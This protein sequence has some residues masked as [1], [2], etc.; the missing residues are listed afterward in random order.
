MILVA[1]EEASL[2]K[3]SFLLI[4]LVVYFQLLLP[5]LAKFGSIV[6]FTLILSSL[7][8]LLYNCIRSNIIV[9]PIKPEN[10]SSLDFAIE[11]GNEDCGAKMVDQATL[12]TF[13]ENIK[14][15]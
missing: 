9:E 15:C 4:I 1:I 5:L 10:S 3:F 6:A 14:P 8:V 7:A 2:L 13:L 11:Q 12:S